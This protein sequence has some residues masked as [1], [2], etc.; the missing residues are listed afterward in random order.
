MRII[1]QIGNDIAAIFNDRYLGQIP[2][3][4]SGR[5]SL[6][7]DIIKHH[8]ELE[9]IRAIENFSTEDVTVERGPNKKSVVVYDKITPINCMSQ[10]YMICTIE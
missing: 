5:V 7:N 2:N 3:D 1:D 4:E 8:K 6:W 10:L 9:D